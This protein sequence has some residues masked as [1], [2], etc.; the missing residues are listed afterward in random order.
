MRARPR[1]VRGDGLE[2]RRADRAAHRRAHGTDPPA[3]ATEPRA[4]RGA[5]VAPVGTADDAFL[6]PDRLADKR[7]ELP[8]ERPAVIRAQLPAIETPV[9]GSKPEAYAQTDPGA[10][11]EAN[12]WPHGLPVQAP[13]PNALA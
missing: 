4:D 10:K 7:A 9:A 2:V 8:P 1:L 11:P 5:V 13:D 12:A 6:R 3:D